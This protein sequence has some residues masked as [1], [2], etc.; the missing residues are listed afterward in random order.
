MPERLYILCIA[1]VALLAAGCASTDDY[2]DYRDMPA[3]GW[4]YADSVTFVPHAAPAAK[5]DLMVALRHSADYP[6]RN[7]WIEVT[8][9][10]SG[11]DSPCRDTLDVELADNFGLWLS[12]GVGSSR[13]IALPVRRNV[14]ID[15]GIPV[16]V[17]HI[18]RLDTLPRIEQVG[19]FIVQP[20]QP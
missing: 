6:Y 1:A 19:L 16:S 17:R 12:H 10:L 18:M 13:Q 2:S 20:N 9:T 14:S 11:S 8:Y 7:L 4:A 15:S 5:G 3:Y